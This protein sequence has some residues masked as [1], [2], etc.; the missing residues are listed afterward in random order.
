MTFTII[1]DKEIE[2]LECIKEGDKDLYNDIVSILT[3]ND[4][5]EEFAININDKTWEEIKDKYIKRLT[6]N[7][8]EL[9]RYLE[10]A[11]YIFVYED[12]KYKLCIPK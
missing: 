9:K 11:N 8:N 1:I 4:I 10:N 6:L 7:E 3:D 12:G 2:N 5:I